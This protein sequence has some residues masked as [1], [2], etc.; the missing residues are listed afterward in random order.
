MPKRIYHPLWT[1]LPI[2]GLFIYLIVRLIQTGP[3]PASAP[4]HF[5]F[6][7]QPDA[8]GSPWLILGITLGF[9]LI[10]GIISIAF[11]E[12]WV[13]SE[14]KKSFNWV[15]L[16]DE[17]SAGFLTG[18]SLGYLNM[19][20]KGETQ[21]T[22]PWTWI[23]ITTAAALIL[24]VLLELWRPFHPN[25]RT[26]I[27]EDTSQ[28]EK[29]LQKRLRDNPAFIYWQSQN[30]LWANLLSVILPL[31]MLG[32][33]IIIW[34]NMPWL[35]VIYILLAVLF[36]FLYGGMRTIVTRQNISVRLGLLGLRVL[37]IKVEDIAGCEIME[38]SP[39]K[40]FGGYGIRFNN[41]MFAFFLRGNRGL[42]IT[43]K[44]NMRYLIGADHPEQLLAVVKAVT[45]L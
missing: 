10:I 20:E 2:L 6:N 14:R 1:H 37:N 36:S 34:F 39:L 19:L 43:L 26:V 42:K 24:A 4:T 41:K 45:N 31:V 38:F 5:G 30:P 29:E 12:I 33:A 35:S 8:Y 13:Q 22:L 7:G 11:D 3:L 9:T 23:L 16:F 17:I 25:P 27:T 21:F 18:L 28:L 15:S 32:A 40:D 44:Q